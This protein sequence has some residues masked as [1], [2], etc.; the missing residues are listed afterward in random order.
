MSYMKKKNIITIF[1]ILILAVIIIFLFFKTINNE[2]SI[3]TDG[4]TDFELKYHITPT[5]KP[6]I[7][8]KGTTI[9]IINNKLNYFKDYP[10]VQ[11]ENQDFTLSQSEVNDLISYILKRDIFSLKSTYTNDNCFDGIDKE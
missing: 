9:T 3:P 7:G 5:T 4:Y 8:S 1:F 2:E 11:E 10:V 6:G